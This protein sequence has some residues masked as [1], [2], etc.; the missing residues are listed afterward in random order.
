METAGHYHQGLVAALRRR[1]FVVELNPFHVKTARAQRGRAG[2]K[3]DERDCMAMIDL[4]VQGKGWPLH[5]GEGAMAEQLAWAAHRR[6][7]TRALQ[8]LGG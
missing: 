4:L 2:I 5:R 8:A 3:T 7:K 6:R 1:K